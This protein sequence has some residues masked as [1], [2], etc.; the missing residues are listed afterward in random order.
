MHDLRQAATG[1]VAGIPEQTSDD[2]EEQDGDSGLANVK[3]RGPLWLHADHLR[4]LEDRTD[5]HLIAMN[6]ENY[7]NWESLFLPRV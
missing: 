5:V 4:D 2:I 6:A 1:I 3:H 7:S